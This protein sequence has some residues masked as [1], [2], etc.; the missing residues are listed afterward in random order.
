MPQGALPG[1]YRSPSL[2]G[3][4]LSGR[5]SGPILIPPCK[6]GDSAAMFSAEPR[7]FAELRPE[8]VFHVWE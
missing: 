6:D 1:S 4:G 3:S 5:L 8:R 7:R 2:A